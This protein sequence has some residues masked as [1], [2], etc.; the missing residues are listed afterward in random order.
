[1]QKH[2]KDRWNDDLLV[3]IAGRYGV[4]VKNLSILDGFESFIYEYKRAGTGY[5]LRVSH[6]LRRSESLIR[7]E[8]DWLNY[9]AQG[10][11]RVAG[12]IESDA[13]N[14]LES[15]ADSQGDMFIATAFRKAP[16]K[17]LDFKDWTPAFVQ[18]YGE[19]IGQIHRLSKDYVPSKPGIARYHWDDERSYTSDHWRKILDPEMMS[20][21]EA[22]LKR[23]Q[24]LPRDDGYHMIHQDAHGGNFF[25]DESGQ[26]TLF[27]FDD[28]V[29][30]HAIDDIAMVIFYGPISRGMQSAEGFTG[31]FLKGYVRQNQLDPQW[32]AHIPD[33]MKLREID[34]Y[35]IIERDVDW[36]NGEDPWAMRFMQG[37]RERLLKNTPFIDFDFTSLATLF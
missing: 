29:Y 25:V 33:F 26:I 35:A 18:H 12:A 22:L 7:G 34:L 2:I 16:G 32:L 31:N 14:L 4:S 9:L 3:E 28:C 37:R 8:I 30:G 20:L 21:A 19:T 11:A 23:L 6:S 15:I 13:G 36:R 24:A 10:G 27:D 17:H 1:M 5:I